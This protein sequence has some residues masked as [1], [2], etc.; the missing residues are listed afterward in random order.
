MERRRKLGYDMYALLEIKRDDTMGRLNFMK[1]NY[2]F[3]GAPVGLIIT[4]DRFADR[5]GW[6]HVGMFLQTLCLVATEMGM[7]TCLQEA[8]S[9]KHK[10]ITEHLDI[11][12]SEIVWCGVALGYEDKSA[13][14]NQLVSERE[15][16]PKFATFKGKL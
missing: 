2:R 6:G 7:A 12:D 3:F 8:W 10:A 13:K 15:P 4:V 9:L 1:E 14:V 11:P 5:N 16:V